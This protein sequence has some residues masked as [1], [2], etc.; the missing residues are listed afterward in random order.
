VSTNESELAGLR[1]FGLPGLSSDGFGNSI[2]EEELALCLDCRVAFNIRNRTC[3][4][5]DGEQFWLVAKWKTSA[6]RRD[7]AST[8]SSRVLA[9][10]TRASSQR[11]MPS[12]SASTAGPPPVIGLDERGGGDGLSA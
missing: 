3:P 9:Y 1:G 12:G 7:S 6:V 4:K 5:C 10:R 11:R 8:L 2:R